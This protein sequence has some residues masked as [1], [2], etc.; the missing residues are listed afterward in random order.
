VFT[1]LSVWWGS[2]YVASHPDMEYVAFI[3]TMLVNGVTEFLFMRFFVFRKTINT[4][5]LAQ[6]RKSE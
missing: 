1:P 3:L 2:G 5:R 4:N 6:R